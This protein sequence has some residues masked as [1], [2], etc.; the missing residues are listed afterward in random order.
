M[1]DMKSVGPRTYR[2]QARAE[3]SERTA[4]RILQATVDIFWERPGT[5]MSMDDVARRAGVSVRTVIRRFGSKEQLVAAAA[6]WS[7]DRVTAQRSQ[8][9]VGDVPASV[10]VLLDHYEEYGDRVLRLLAAEVEVPALAAVA[11]RGRQVHIHWCRE[12]FAPFLQRG[13]AAVRERRLAQF[14]TVCD[15]YSWKLLRRDAGLSRSQTRIAL[16]EMLTPL[17]LEPS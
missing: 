14:V 12:V 6:E 15:V 2:M 7:A 11:D 9:P 1:T 10:D 13:T 3:S 4:Q 8:A 5:D 16:I 17:T